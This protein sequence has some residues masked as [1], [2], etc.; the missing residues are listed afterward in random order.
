V[1]AQPRV[2]VDRQI[3]REAARLVDK[4]LADWAKKLIG[5]NRISDITLEKLIA[6]MDNYF[7]IFSGMRRVN[8]SAYK[9][10]SNI[11]APITVGESCIWRWQ[12]DQTVI[13]N[14]DKLPSYFGVFFTKDPTEERE[15][16]YKDGPYFPEFVFFEKLKNAPTFAPHG[17]TIFSHNEVSLDQH[18]LSKEEAKKFPWAK[19]NWGVHWLVGVLPDGTIKP[20]PCRMT[21][22]QLLPRRARHEP[23]GGTRHH[24]V[25]SSRFCIPEGLVEWGMGDADQLVRSR[26]NM[27]LAFTAT[28]ISGAQL[29]LKKNGVTARIGVPISVVRDFFSDRDRVDGERRKP[30]MNLILPHERHYKDG[31]ITIVGEHLRGTRFFNWR[32]YEM[33]IGA[34]GLHYPSIEGFDAGVYDFEQPLPPECDGEK[35]KAIETL[36]PIASNQIWR[37]D[38]RLQ[39]RKGSPNQVFRDANLPS[40]ADGPPKLP[41]AESPAP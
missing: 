36:A 20:L 35:M 7:D 12:L 22:S 2:R 32:G 26:F 33:S 21:R 10:F 11:G 25:H 18:V 41:S 13:P 34:P 16:I 30:L 17:T 40:E 1:P 31:H 14:A 19:R 8:T 29:T 9:F 27:A 4:P 5:D 15:E 23:T 24:Y 3:Q 39:F 38:R 28:A 37:R 6:G